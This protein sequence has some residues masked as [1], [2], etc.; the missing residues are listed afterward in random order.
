MPTIVN[1]TKYG[2]NSE[3]AFEKIKCLRPS[4][5]L[6]NIPYINKNKG[7]LKMLHYN[8]L[9][10]YMQ[11]NYLTCIYDEKIESLLFVKFDSKLNICIRSARNNDY[12]ISVDEKNNFI[13][14]SSQIEEHADYCFI[15]DFI[16]ALNSL[17]FNTKLD[18]LLTVK[19]E[20]IT[21]RKTKI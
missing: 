10:T 14:H 15:T 1:V 4:D 18:N 17:S 2:F 9:K 6:I 5:S 8:N 16:S 7:T 11:Q 20:S 12:L 19:D 3:S 13:Y 21:V